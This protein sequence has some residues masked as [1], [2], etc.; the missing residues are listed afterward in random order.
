MGE[1]IR[2]EALHFRYGTE[3]ASEK[4]MDKGSALGHFPV[5]EGGKEKVMINEIGP[6]GYFDKQIFLRIVPENIPTHM[7]SLGLPVKP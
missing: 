5:I 6:V 4:I 2:R 1:V 7:G 3:F